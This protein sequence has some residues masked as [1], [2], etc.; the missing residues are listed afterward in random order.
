[1]TY[2]SR[3]AASGPGRALASDGRA[4]DSRR[5]RPRAVPWTTASSTIVSAT[6]ASAVA[7]AHRRRADE[8]FQTSGAAAREGPSEQLKRDAV[9][10]GVDLSEVPVR[11]T[12]DGSNAAYAPEAPRGGPDTPGAPDA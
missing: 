8:L 1:M 7:E 12:T 9:S 11:A 2:R 3:S 5:R 4:H 6:T 10:D